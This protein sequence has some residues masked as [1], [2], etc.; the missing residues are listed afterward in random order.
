M[1][2]RLYRLHRSVAATITGEN[3]Y[4]LALTLVVMVPTGM[5]HNIY[6]EHHF[7]LGHA[8]LHYCT[9]YIVIRHDLLAGIVSVTF[10][11]VWY[12]LVVSVWRGA[13]A[14]THGNACHSHRLLTSTAR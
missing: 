3:A 12:V 6:D 1:I 11:V 4:A 7:D 14:C 8:G 5:K 2:T 13:G 10:F 9:A